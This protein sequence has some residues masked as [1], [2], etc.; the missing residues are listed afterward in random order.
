[1]DL[2]GVAVVGAAAVFVAAAA[3]ANLAVHRPSASIVSRETVVDANAIQ[4]KPIQAKPIRVIALGKSDRM[5]FAERAGDMLPATPVTTVVKTA[6][7]ARAGIQVALAEP[8][9]PV[10][11][12]ERLGEPKPRHVEAGDICTKHGLHKVWLRGGRQWRCR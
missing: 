5:T 2:R 8:E 1:M 7:P 12:S 3:A 11:V 9:A 6:E 4:A 10:S